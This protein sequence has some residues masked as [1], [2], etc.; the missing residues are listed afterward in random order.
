MKDFARKHPAA[1][2]ESPEWN[3]LYEMLMFHI[4]EETAR[5]IPSTKERRCRLPCG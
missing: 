3:S 4:D 2:G 5:E 1:V